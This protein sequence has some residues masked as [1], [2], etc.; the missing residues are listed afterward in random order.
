MSYVRATSVPAAFVPVPLL[1]RVRKRY[2]ECLAQRA[3]PY[4]ECLIHF[5]PNAPGSTD[6]V[7]LI[8]VPP[9]ASAPHAVTGF[10]DPYDGNLRYPW[11]NDNTTSFMTHAQVKNAI[12]AAMATSTARA[13]HR[14]SGPYRAGSASAQPC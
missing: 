14:R 12:M 11:R 6:G 13:E 3:A 7:M 4:A 1:D 9:S 10:K 2:R 5:I 8:A